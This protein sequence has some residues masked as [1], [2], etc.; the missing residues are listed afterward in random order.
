M[1]MKT[2]TKQRRAIRSLLSPTDPADALTTYYAL[3]H[4]A[5]RT[6]LTLHRT[7]KGEV[8][9]FLAEC[10]TG[11]DLFRPLVVMRAHSEDALRWLL[12]QSLRAGRAYYFVAPPSLASALER[13]L[14]IWQPT[15]THIYR[16]YTPHFVPVINVLVVQNTGHNHLSRFEIRAGDKAMAVAGL[17]WRSPRF[18]E[19]YVYTEPEARRRGWARS[20]LS[21][22][23]AALLQEGLT[24]LYM[25]EEGNTASIHLAE[26]LGYRDTGARQFICFGTLPDQ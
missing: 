24:P 6:R 10:V 2:L 18:A 14:D 9:G 21:A 20:V 5:R 4:D 19:V 1:N 16:L 7:D 26:S 8:D 13:H 22:C 15:T 11:F 17:N 25:V 23:T 3:Y 12:E